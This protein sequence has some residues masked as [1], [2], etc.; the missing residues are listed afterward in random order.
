MILLAKQLREIL[1]E[2]SIHGVNFSLDAGSL[3]LSRGECGTPIKTIVTIIGL[4]NK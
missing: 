3:Q 2:E 4:K 1:A